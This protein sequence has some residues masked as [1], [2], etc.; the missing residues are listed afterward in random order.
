MFDDFSLVK[1]SLNGVP[2]HISAVIQV[3][4]CEHSDKVTE[5]L[6]AD[7]PMVSALIFDSQKWNNCKN[8]AEWGKKNNL[9]IGI[10][11]DEMAF[12]DL[13]TAL[14]SGFIEFVRLGI[15]KEPETKKKAFL[16]RSSGIKHEF[17][18]GLNSDDAS[19]A[20][21]AYL[22]VSPCDSFVV[23]ANKKLK[24][25]TKTSLMELATKYKSLFLR[26]I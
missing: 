22:L 12:D 5:T 21:E 17:T 9:R 18:F 6:L 23:E 3:N 26:L 24:D 25:D 13:K 15:K 10:T 8:I 7:N 2:G 20:E 19:K 16:I 11:A 4:S 1:R 14:E